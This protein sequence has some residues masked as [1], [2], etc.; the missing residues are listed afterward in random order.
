MNY[1]DPKREK[2]TSTMF[3]SS[4]QKGSFAVSIKELVNFLKELRKCI[5]KNHKT[6]TFIKQ[7]FS[8]LLFKVQS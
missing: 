3:D 4:G 6:D 2:N 7:T 1:A 5:T 8:E